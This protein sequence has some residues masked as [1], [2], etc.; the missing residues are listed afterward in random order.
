MVIEELAFPVDRCFSLREQRGAGRDFLPRYRTLDHDKI[1][2]LRCE[3]ERSGVR[4]LGQRR[5]DGGKA[6]RIRPRA[7]LRDRYR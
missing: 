5:W 2:L 6:E 3:F 7:T 1:A 4:F